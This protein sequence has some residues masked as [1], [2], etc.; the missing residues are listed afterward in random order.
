MLEP[1]WDRWDGMG[2]KSLYAMAIRKAPFLK[3]ILQFVSSFW[4]TSYT[5][6]KLAMKFFRPEIHDQN[7]PFLMQKKL[8][9]NYLDWKWNPPPIWKLSENTSILGGCK[10]NV[11][12][13]SL[14]LLRETCARLNGWIFGKF[15]KGGGG[16]L[17]R[18]LHLKQTEKSENTE[19][20]SKPW[21]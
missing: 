4:Q 5:S 1:K 2:W 18:N 7:V 21:I 12:F 20:Y 8:Q 14:L 15:P 16:V 9:W 6:T 3:N 13:S 11:V 17:K 10:K 19:K